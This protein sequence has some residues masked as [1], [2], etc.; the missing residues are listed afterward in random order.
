MN[1][2]QVFSGEAGVRTLEPAWRALTAQVAPR[3]HFHHVEWYLALAATLDRHGPGPLN[4][5]AVFSE[6]RRLAAVL[7]M[8]LVR[9][10]IGP[11]KLNAI[12]LVSDHLD[13]ETARD[14]VLSPG[15]TQTSFLQGFVR[16]LAEHETSWDVIELPGILEDSHA[17]EA[18]RHSPQIP[19]LLLPGGAWGRCEFIS[20]AAGDRPFERLSKGF[21]QNLRTSGNKLKT[22]SVAFEFARTED[23]LLQLFPEFLKVESSGWKGE[24]GT[25]V[26]KTP[27]A[28]TFLRKLIAHFASIGGCEIHVMRKDHASIAALF[29]IVTD[30]IWYIFR[31]GYDET[32]H[33]ASPGHLIIENLL[34]RRAAHGSFDVLTPY[35][36]PPWFQAW[37]PDKALS[38]FNA[39]L[40]RPSPK[41]LE[42][43][44]HVAMLLQAQP[45]RSLS[46]VGIP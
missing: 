19:H 45:G 4:C 24:L 1:R 16:H 25:S 30:G 41:G 39:Y 37:K 8:R 20:C 34:R 32:Y 11:L 22:S 3:R 17:A 31:I 35:N 21:R 9:T 10:E 5:I 33:R 2:F 12:R 44:R 23:A 14:I 46:A 7:P 13:N 28:D 42:L 40:F 15:L 38:L 29:G 36:A 18:L 27:I 6:D 26:L 43:A